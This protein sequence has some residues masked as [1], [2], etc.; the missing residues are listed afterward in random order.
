MQRFETIRLSVKPVD[1][2]PD[3]A[4]VRTLLQLKGEV[5]RTSNSDRVKRDSP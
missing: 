5:W 3:G 1:L 2:A 4:E